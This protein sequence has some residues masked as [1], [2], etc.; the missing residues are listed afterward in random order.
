MPS[1]P[2]SDL[3]QRTPR[4]R[5]RDGARQSGGGWPRGECVCVVYTRVCVCVCCVYVCVCVCVCVRVG[6]CCVY[7]CVCVWVRYSAQP[8]DV[9]TLVIQQP[10]MR[11]RSLLHQKFCMVIRLT[12]CSADVVVCRGH[13]QKAER[14]QG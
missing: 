6:V 10:G 7:T 4:N 12:S 14:M 13:M 1:P 3:C 9:D 5:R 11:W 2:F 8:G